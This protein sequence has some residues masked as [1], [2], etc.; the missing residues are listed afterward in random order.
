MTAPTTERRRSP[1]FTLVEL[2]VATSILL[3]ILGILLS[4]TSTAS[5]IWQFGSARVS[6][7]QSSRAAFETMTRSIS[8]A[9]LNTYYDYYGTSSVQPGQYT[10]RTT[11]N[12]GTNGVFTPVRYGRRSELEF[13]CGKNLVDST[14]VPGGQITHAIFFQTPLNYT[15][16]AD[17]TVSGASGY[18]QLTGLLNTIGFF[19]QFSDDS[20][21]IPG[22]VKS[23]PRYRY[24]LMEL[25]QPTENFEVYNVYNTNQD[26]LTHAWFTN[27]IK[28]DATS[29][30]LLADN[31]VACVIC[32]R[33]PQDP[34]TTGT[35]TSS[36]TNDYEYDSV[37]ANLP[38]GSGVTSWKLDPSNPSPQPTNM[39]QLPPSVRVVLVAVDETSM[40]HLTALSSGTPSSQQA[41]SAMGLSGTASYSTL[42]Q[43]TSNSSQLDDDLYTLTSALSGNKPPINYRVFQTD[44]AIR[45]AKWS[46]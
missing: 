7:F 41:A 17:T 4:M 38:T 35:F 12:S 18:G 11:L 34:A 20:S 10:F 13:V 21:I 16:T 3:V 14:L 43:S 44:V 2:L 31:I 24:R 26:A 8:I 6:A 29:V 42:F 46:P 37:I 33:L 15:Q 30:R 45:G 40:V 19:V 36:L 27:S 39:N 5:R 25:L 23:Q 1:G 9:T 32:P 28:N 22:F